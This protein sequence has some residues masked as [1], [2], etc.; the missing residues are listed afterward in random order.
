MRQGTVLR[1]ALVIAAALAAV[2]GEA[3][4]QQVEASTGAALASANFPAPQ[5]LTI[6]LVPPVSANSVLATAI[7][8]PSQALTI[9]LVP[10][11]SSNAVLATA[12]FPAPRALSIAL[13][14][15]GQVVTSPAPVPRI[16]TVTR[17]GSGVVTASVVDA[18][19]TVAHRVPVVCSAGAANCEASVA[20]GAQVTLTAVAAAG[21]S[22]ASWSGCDS[23]AGADCVMLVGAAKSVTANFARVQQTVTVTLAGTGTVAGNVVDPGATTPRTLPID[24]AAGTCQVTVNEGAGLTLRASPAAGFS[25]ASWSGCDSVAGADCVMLVGAAKSVTANFARVQRTVTVT[26]AGSGTVTAST[27]DLGATTPRTL[28]I[29]CATGTCQATANDGARLTLSAT[30]AAGF[31]F[32]SWNGCDSVTGADCVIVV[33]TAK[34]VTAN[35][36]RVQ[37]APAAPAPVVIDPLALIGAAQLPTPQPLSVVLVPP[38]T[39]LALIGNAN[40]PLPQ[41]LSVTLVPPASPYAAIG[42]AN[43][44]TPQP[45]SVVLVQSAPTP[46]P[47]AVAPGTSGSAAQGAGPVEFSVQIV[48][49]IPRRGANFF[50][51]TDP[52]GQSTVSV[53][54]TTPAAAGGSSP[55]S[56]AVGATSGPIVYV[57][58]FGGIDLFPDTGSLRV[59][60]VGTTQ[61][62]LE[63]VNPADHTPT[64]G[65]LG[66]VVPIVFTPNPAGNTLFISAVGH[67]NNGVILFGRSGANVCAKRESFTLNGI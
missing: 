31:S 42:N 9:T 20:D 45:L 8:P 40:F 27:I 11:P 1:R 55:V 34:S 43:F 61:I 51:R 52:T 50:D 5:T 26:Q 36:A 53:V 13:V 10:P 21:F 19:L 7:F 47:L 22:F 62:R 54:A 28:P 32:T 15:G 6:M 41:A 2:A 35:F 4:A 14:P 18:G 24:C 3:V 67:D 49:V 38:P 64:A 56:C 66:N 57:N 25:F 16:L 23:V 46:S 33:S 58:R 37:P 39:P 48:Q 29:D 17:S 12:D 44:P 65:S 59:M 60:P 63:F 30:P